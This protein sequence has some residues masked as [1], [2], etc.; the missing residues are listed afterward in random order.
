MRAT[1]EDLVFSVTSAPAEIVAMLK[2]R[3]Q[4]FRIQD[5]QENQMQEKED[6]IA[7]HDALVQGTITTDSIRFDS[8]MRCFLVRGTSD[9]V[10]IVKLGS[11]PT[12]SCRPVG[13]CYHITSV[14][15]A[16]GLKNNSDKPKKNLTMLRRNK[17]TQRQK[18]GR[19]RARPGDYDV[20]AAPDAEEGKLRII[21]N[22]I[23]NNTKESSEMI[24]D[25]C[26]NK[27]LSEELN[28]DGDI[29]RPTAIWVA[30][31]NVVQQDKAII[32]SG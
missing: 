14:M 7:V 11:K 5:P 8:H 2:S 29:P 4:T 20:A 24:L 28:N 3:I 16:A 32:S 10:H 9:V 17:R 1:E 22:D 27:T 18:P 25:E 30:H 26:I 19:K 12:C 6:T 13:M 23:E 15:V 31:L 21:E